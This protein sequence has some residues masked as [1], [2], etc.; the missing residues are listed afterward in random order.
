MNAKKVC[1]V[2]VPCLLAA[3]ST[4][5]TLGD[6]SAKTV[7]T[8][9]AGGASAQGANAQL[10]HCPKTLG[11]LAIVEEANQP[12]LTALRSQYQMQ[13]TVRCCAS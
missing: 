10:E 11:T 8:G 5:S 7:A 2:L 12:W 3:C 13:S 4:G 1:A 9:S 6:S